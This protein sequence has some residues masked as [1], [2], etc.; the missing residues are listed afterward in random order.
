MKSLYLILEA[1]AGTHCAYTPKQMPGS[2]FMTR[3]VFE[4]VLLYAQKNGLSL[5][6]ICGTADPKEYLDTARQKGVSIFTIGSFG[7]TRNHHLTVGSIHEALQASAKEG[8][9]YGNCAI[10]LRK[11]DL[12]GLAEALASII[13]YTYRINLIHLDLMEYDQEDRDLYSAELFRVAQGLASG[14]ISSQGVE[15]APLTDRLFLTR[16]RDCGAGVEN[17]TVTPSGEVTLCPAFYYSGAKSLGTLENF[18]LPYA[19]HYR[20]KSSPVC[21]LCDAYHCRRCLYLNKQYTQEY[22][23]PPAE[24]CRLSH[25]ER[26]ASVKVVKEDL[27]AGLKSIKELS[28]DDPF[29]LTQH[30]R[31]GYLPID[32]RIEHLVEL[33]GHPLLDLSPK[34]LLNAVYRLDPDIIDKLKAFLEMQNGT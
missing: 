33:L 27:F 6:L 8:Q 22:L 16:H 26:A 28:Y 17:L 20:L 5:N 18:V 9:S 31:A 21:T 32:E 29:V 4:S 10:R 3:K 13:P 14:R 12:M 19:D 24:Q 25:S 7:S 2:Q 15:L 11:A 34:S 30:G 1:G 23:V